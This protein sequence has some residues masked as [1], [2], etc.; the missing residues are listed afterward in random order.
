MLTRRQLVRGVAFA[1]AGL[2]VRRRVL[3][4]PV[5][6][7]SIGDQV[8]TLPKGQ[9][10]DFATHATDVQRMYRY[11]VEDHDLLPYIPCFCGCVRFG[12][13]SNRD[14]YVTSVHDDGSIS[15]TSHAAI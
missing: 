3:A 10:P 4:G 8:R 15:F 5:A 14:C 12:H 1:G 7:G 2:V 6:T 13:R 9:L 11:A